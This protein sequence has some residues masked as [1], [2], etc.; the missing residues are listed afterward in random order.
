MRTPVWHDTVAGI[1]CVASAA[2]THD[3]V[4]GD[5]GRDRDRVDRF[6]EAVVWREGIHAIGDPFELK[7]ARVKS[8]YFK[9]GS[10]RAEQRR[11]SSYEARSDPAEPVACEIAAAQWRRYEDH[12]ADFRAMPKDEGIRNDLLVFGRERHLIR[13]LIEK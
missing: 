11:G 3:R 12:T 8:G 13:R 5:T 2:I 7:V 1:W 4:I 6:H 10:A 9:G